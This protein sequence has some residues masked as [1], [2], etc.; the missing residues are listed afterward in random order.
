MVI[1]HTLAYLLRHIG[2]AHTFQREP[3]KS[4]QK[5]NSSVLSD[6]SAIARRTSA[7]LTTARMGIAP[8]IDPSTTRF[9]FPDRSEDLHQLGIVACVY[10]FMSASLANSYATLLFMIRYPLSSF[11]TRRALET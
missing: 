5:A 11:A 2:T 4:M 3:L 7:G 10:S 8:M 6:I 9:R 1:Y